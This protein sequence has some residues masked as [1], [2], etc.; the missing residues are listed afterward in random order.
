M[1]VP[2]PVH[3]QMEPAR[4]MARVI[5][6]WAPVATAPDSW[7]PLPVMREKKTLSTPMARKI[8][9]ISIFHYL[10]DVQYAY[11]WISF[12]CKNHKKR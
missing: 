9:L 4:E 8:Q 10:L 6:A 5:P 1:S 3:R 11:F 12:I 2:T 7:G